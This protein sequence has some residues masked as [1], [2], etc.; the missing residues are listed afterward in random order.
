MQ[1]RLE[2]FIAIYVA[3]KFPYYKTLVSIKELIDPIIE[4]CYM[5]TE[6]LVQIIK[7]V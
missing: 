6:N 2:F 3:W 5:P 4:F 7:R 1:E